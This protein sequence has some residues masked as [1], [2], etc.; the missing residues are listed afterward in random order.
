MSAPAP[1]AW[2]RRIAG[3]WHGRPSLFD[4]TG[5]WCGFEDIRRSSEFDDGRTVYR[6]DGGLEG[7]GPEAVTERTSG[8]RHGEE[9]PR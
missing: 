1:S 5:T 4:A 7:G 2:Q 8:A 9:T 6:M 3:E